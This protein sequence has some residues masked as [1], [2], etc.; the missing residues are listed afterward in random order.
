MKLK[1]LPLEPIQHIM[2]ILK[3][4]ACQMKSKAES[5]VSMELVA[6][7][8]ALIMI[9]QLTIQKV[10]LPQVNVLLMANTVKNTAS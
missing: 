5:K 1:S 3:T 10:I 6:S 9:A 8:T 2:E 4:A 7:Q